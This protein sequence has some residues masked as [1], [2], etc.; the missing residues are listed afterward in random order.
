MQS[1]GTKKTLINALTNT[2]LVVVA[3]TEWP[4]KVLVFEVTANGTKLST[5]VKEATNTGCK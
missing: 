4:F 1:F 2:F 5:K 3:L